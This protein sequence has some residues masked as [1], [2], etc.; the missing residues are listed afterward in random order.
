MEMVLEEY[1]VNPRGLT[2]V[3]YNFGGG[4]GVVAGFSWFTSYVL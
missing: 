4:A 1:L 3:I 2:D